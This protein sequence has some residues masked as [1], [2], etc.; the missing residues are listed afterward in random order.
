MGAARNGTMSVACKEAVV[1]VAASIED[2]LLD[3]LGEGTLGDQ[4]TN[5]DGSIAGGSGRDVGA[6]L[7]IDGGGRAEGAL[8]FVVDDLRV[9][10]VVGAEHSQARTGGG[11]GEIATQTPVAFLGVLLAGQ[12]GHGSN[13]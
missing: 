7:L 5:G 2:H 3:A 11:A 9:D 13:G 6:Q 8:R 4:L 10:V 12:C 1:Q